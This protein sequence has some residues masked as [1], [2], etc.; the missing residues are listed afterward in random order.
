MEIEI[1]GHNSEARDFPVLGSE[2]AN[3][4]YIERTGEHD[5]FFAI[6]VDMELEELMAEAETACY[7]VCVATR[8]ED[9]RQKVFVTKRV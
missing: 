5:P 1:Y 2:A 6:V 4:E 7:V 9:E 8:R 3:Y